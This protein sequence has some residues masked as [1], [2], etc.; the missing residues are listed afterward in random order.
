VLASG[1]CT[2]HRPLRLAPTAPRATSVETSTAALADPRQQAAVRPHS[3]E[4]HPEFELA[5]VEFD[6]QGRFWDRGQLE[7]LEKTLQAA[8]ED[9]ETSGPAIVIFAHGWRHGCDVCDQNVTCFRTFLKQ[10]YSDSSSAVRLSGGNVKRKRIVGVYVGWRGLSEKYRP[11][12]DL[13]FWARKRVAQRIGEQDLVELLMRVEVFQRR[14]NAQDPGRARLVLIGH[15]LGGTMVYGALANVLKVR[16]LQAA[17]SPADPGAGADVIHG[18]GDLVLLI[19]PAFEASLYAPLHDIATGFGRFSARQT[20]VMI[21]VASETDKPNAMWFPLGRRLDTISQKTGDRSSRKE[22]VTAVG[23]Y[24][25]FWTH[26][27]TPRETPPPA[28]GK[29]ESK[30]MSRRCSCELPVDPI[31]AAEA[32]YLESL[33]A[34]GQRLEAPA[35]AAVP[36][37]R[38]MLTTLRP[39]DPN[40][41]FWVVRASDDVVRGHSGIFTTYLLDFVRRIIIEASSRARAPRAS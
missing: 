18:F 31:E 26:R 25:P 38:A 22:L 19:N 7:L 32:Q 17:A 1:G 27:L 21:T 2:A 5:F 12:E 36:Y 9:R 35:G 16:A 39:I 3:V 40:N 11:F 14:A 33:V 13:S 29:R 41:P 4:I 6:D 8:N 20:P 37:G 23:N 28:P 34:G 30:A 15:S 10:I 24:E